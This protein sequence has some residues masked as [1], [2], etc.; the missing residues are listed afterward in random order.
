MNTLRKL[1]LLAFGFSVSIG[2]Y[3]NDWEPATLENSE[4]LDINYARC[5]YKANYQNYRFS[6]IIKGSSIE[7]PTWIEYNPVT[8]QWR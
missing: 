8:G 5:Y 4:S 7:C 1:A 6:F 3:A 2:S